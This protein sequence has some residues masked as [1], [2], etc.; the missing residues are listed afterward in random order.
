MR[1]IQDFIA[2]FHRQRRWTRALVEAVP[3]D[4][5]GWAPGPSDFSCGGLVR[6]LMLAEV[7]FR[8]M[9]LA[10]ARGEN[11]NPFGLPGS[12]AERTEAFRERNL[13]L[14]QEEKYGRTFAECLRVWEGIE[15]KTAEELSAIPDEA[16]HTREAVH[17]LTG[18][19]APLWEMCIVMVGH[20]AHHRGQLSAY[21]KLLGLPQPPNFS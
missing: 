8:R 12:L 1:T 20:E 14:S 18:L 16:L 4:R 21:L 3:E 17:G 7:S 9:L 15:R 10:A 6:H 5:F 11:Y 19:K 13:R 2:H